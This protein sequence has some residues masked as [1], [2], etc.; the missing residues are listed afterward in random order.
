M[1][2]TGSARTIASC[3]FIRCSSSRAPASRVLAR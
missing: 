1:A 2:M 3:R